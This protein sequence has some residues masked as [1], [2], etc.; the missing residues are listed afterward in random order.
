MH[1]C[2]LEGEYGGEA[3]GNGADEE[4]LGAG[5]VVGDGGLGRSVHRLELVVVE[6]GHGAE[7]EHYV[8][9]TTHPHQGEQHV[10]HTHT[11]LGPAAQVRRTLGCNIETIQHSDCTLYFLSLGCNIQNTAL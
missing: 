2:L 1:V 11:R 8:Q 5:G 7:Q 10:A 3:L 9:Q 6:G 4:K